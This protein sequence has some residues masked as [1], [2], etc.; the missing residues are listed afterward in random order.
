MLRRVSNSQWKS[1]MEQYDRI[2]TI[3]NKHSL[4]LNQ[5]KNLSAVFP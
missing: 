5:G 3:Y 1:E 2:L 4:L